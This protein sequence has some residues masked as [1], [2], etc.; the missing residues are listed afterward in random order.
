MGRAR[1]ERSVAELRKW[2]RIIDQLARSLERG[3]GLDSALAKRAFTA[4]L[5]TSAKVAA[6][7]HRPA[8]DERREQLVRARQ[9]VLGE[10][11]GAADQFLAEHIPRAEDRKQARTA[12][13]ELL[14]DAT[15]LGVQ[16]GTRVS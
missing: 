7:P 4:T 13:V 16:E 15:D 2:E 10:L 11:K 6:A 14:L 1:R 5:T 12:L 8:G 9:R 3:A